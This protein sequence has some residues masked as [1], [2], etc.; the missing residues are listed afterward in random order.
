MFLVF[1]IISCALITLACSYK[2]EY[3]AYSHDNHG[4]DEKPSSCAC[5]KHLSLELEPE[6]VIV[7]PEDTNPNYIVKPLLTMN[8]VSSTTSLSECGCNH[9][10]TDAPNPIRTPQLSLSSGASREARRASAPP[11]E[12]LGWLP[13]F[14]ADEDSNQLPTIVIMASYAT[15]GAALALSVASDSNGCGVMAVDSDVVVLSLQDGIKSV[16]QHA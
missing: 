3:S 7:M 8:N 5:S 10:S 1:S 14:K 15:F 16:E 13:G 12:N 6:I 4:D 9:N 2:K 11:S